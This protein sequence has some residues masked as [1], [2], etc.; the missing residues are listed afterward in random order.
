MKILHSYAMKQAPKLNVYFL[1]LVINSYATLCPDKINYFNELAG[2]LHEKLTIG[3]S[4][5]KQTIAVKLENPGLIMEYIPDITTYS[6]LWL[7]I[8]C[9]GI[10]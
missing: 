1:S 5:N 8:T 10:K 2:E 9:F 3:M 6:N 7:A 4:P